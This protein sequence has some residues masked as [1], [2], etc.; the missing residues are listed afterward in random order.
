MVVHGCV[1]ACVAGDGGFCVHA[2]SQAAQGRRV[3]ELEDAAQRSAAT[4]ADKDRQ[5]VGLVWCAAGD[6]SAHVGVVTVLVLCLV[7]G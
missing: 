4:I 5:L 2:V 3:A 6:A 1:S 7:T